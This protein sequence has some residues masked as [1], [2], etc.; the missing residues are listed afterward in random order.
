MAIVKGLLSTANAFQ[1]SADFS[2]LD[3][4]LKL[5]LPSEIV[6]GYLEITNDGFITQNSKYTTPFIKIMNDKQGTLQ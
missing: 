1:F 5:K 2:I 6:R 3:I 4:V